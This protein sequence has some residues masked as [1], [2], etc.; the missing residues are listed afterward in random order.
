MSGKIFKIIELINDT[1][2]IPLSRGEGLVLILKIFIGHI[3]V[4]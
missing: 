2:L 1:A 3:L 4:T